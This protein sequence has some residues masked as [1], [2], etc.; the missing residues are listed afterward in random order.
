ML[1]K[2]E[3]G[4]LEWVGR[5]FSISTFLLWGKDVSLTDNIRV[6]SRKFLSEHPDF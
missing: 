5:V 2:T 1:M 3:N 6:F 4:T